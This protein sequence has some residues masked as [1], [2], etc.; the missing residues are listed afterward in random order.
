MGGDAGSMLGNIAGRVFGVLSAL[1]SRGG[2][3]SNLANYMA[4]RQ[5]AMSDPNVRAGLTPFSA[6]FYNIGGGM[7]PTPAGPGYYAPVASPR[8]FMG[9]TMPTP[10]G[11]MEYVPGRPGPSV[12]KPHLPAL[13]PE[14]ALQQ[15]AYQQAQIGLQSTDVATRA[16]AKQAAKI[17]LTADETQALVADASATLPNLPAGSTISINTPSG[18]ISVGSPYALPAGAVK[19]PGQG[20]MPLDQL[21]PQL[22]PG[23]VPQATGRTNAEG[24]PLYQGVTPPKVDLRP[25]TLPPL[26]SPQPVAPGGI[27]PPQ[28]PAEVAPP[29][30]PAPGHVNLSAPFFRQLEAERG[31]PAGVM[32]GLAEQESGGD[33][34][35]ATPLSSARGLYQ[36]TKDTARAWGVSANDR[37]DPVK[38]AI[39]TANTLAERAQQHG[40]TRA[41]GMHY[42]GPAAPFLQKVGPSGLSPAQFAASVLNK[43]QKYA[44]A[45]A[46]PFSPSAAYAA[47]APPPQPVAPPPPPQPIAPAPAPAVV[48]PPPP[49]PPQPPPQ[50]ARV[51]V[52]AAPVPAPAPVQVASAMPPENLVG[53]PPPAPTEQVTT[54]PP[55]VIALPPTAGTQLV[56]P[57]G[58]A[59][60]LGPGGVPLESV[61]I[62]SQTG[63]KRTFKTPEDLAAKQ[64]ELAM[65][66]DVTRLR[67]GGTEADTRA[68]NVI[69]FY[70]NALG[71][72]KQDFPRPQDRAPFLGGTGAQ[73][74]VAAGLEHLGVDNP[75]QK[76]E[77]RLAP[78]RYKKEE[79]EALAGM[80]PVEKSFILPHVPTG[81]ETPGRFEEKIA[82]LQDGIEAADAYRT[83][84]AQLPVEQRTPAMQGEIQRQILEQRA[85]RR[86]AEAQAA[87]QRQPAAVIVAPQ[88]PPPAA[89]PP[90]AAVVVPAAPSAPLAAFGPQ[91]PPEA[92][93]VGLGGAPVVAVAPASTLARTFLPE[94]SL[95]SE[96]LSIGGGIAGGLVG[97][98][99]GPAAPVVAPVL[100]GAGS[101]AGEAGQVGLEH[102]MG[103]PPAEPGTLTERMA[104]AGARGAVGEGAGQ[105]LR[106]GARVV[107]RVAGP[108]FGAAEKVAPVLAQ[109]LPAGT[110]AV[111]TATPGIY[112]NIGRLLQKP[113]AL[114]KAELS[115]EGQETLLRAWWQKVAPGGAKKVIAEWDRLGPEAQAAMAGEQ[116]AAMDTIVESLR[117]STAPISA[118]T[119]MEIARMGT[120]SPALL[121]AGFPKTAMAVGGAELASR[122]APRALLYP[123][124]ATFLSSLPGTTRV[125]SPYISGLVRAGGQTLAATPAPQAAP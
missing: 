1:P 38:A 101:A 121:H 72:L 56:A 48:A 95:P 120:V 87:E 36:I 23:Q 9:P 18:T 2:G 94:R 5:Q 81:N 16:R 28:P 19:T 43:S 37:Y 93:A 124:A 45:V 84:L 58:P 62:E 88:A 122:Y 67:G 113:E 91:G 69:G 114:A 50:P 103:W 97:G 90:A 123:Q 102:V 33:P 105:V 40:I 14:A 110:Q 63:E 49:P 76:F 83:T 24:Q 73:R 80:D 21:Q 108:L 98:L 89:P 65:Q 78:F 60:I 82:A 92:A 15:E 10:A 29:P 86:D 11:P 115:P 51:V 96:G 3:F 66:A 117:P 57:G 109:D 46:A 4:R 20:E 104:R 17:P 68:L 25:P 54:M 44:T 107:G 70:R 12:W 99:A 125:A 41:V 77:E 74:L 22:L 64:R 47:E 85:A 30:P 31:L 39:A 75:N 79:K 34:N 32:S 7:E 52:A 116:H 100:A 8:D 61:S 13:A 27:T 106:G 53:Y 118:M 71:E 26:G 55:T 6:G 112:R 59:P 35:A 111:E 119:P 42:G